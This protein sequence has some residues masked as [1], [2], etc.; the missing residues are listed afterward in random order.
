MEDN[1][2]KS[3]SNYVLKNKHQDVNNGY[4]LERDITTIGGVDQFAKGQIPIYKSSN[5]IITVNNEIAPKRDL[6]DDGFN[7]WTEEDLK[8]NTDVDEESDKIVVRQNFYK[9]KD[10]AYYG[11]CVELIRSSLNNI[12]INYPGSLVSSENNVYYTKNGELEILGKDGFNYLINNP[13]SINIHTEY[14]DEKKVENPIK[15][16]ANEGYKKYYKNITSYSISP[17]LCNN[18]NI[19][20]KKGEYIAEIDINGTKIRAYIGDEGRIYYLTNTKSNNVIAEPKIDVINEFFN[21]LD[22]FE[23]VLLNRNSTPKYTASFEVIDENDY[24]YDTEIRQFT[25]PMLD[26]YNLD[27]ITPAYDEYVNN[28]YYYA[29]FYDE[30]FCD[31]LYR[32][33]TH[34]SIKNFDWSY[35]RRYNNGDEKEY[36]IGGNKIKK[37]IRLFGREF[38][39]IKTYIDG[40]KNYN[41]IEYGETST[42]PEYFLNDS[43]INDG[44]DVVNI[45]PFSSSFTEIT[46]L[47]GIKPYS[48]DIVGKG[49]YRLCGEISPAN[50]DKIINIDDSII[51][52]N[53]IRNFSSE[54]EYSLKEINKH[55]MKILKLNSKSILSKKGTIEGIESL[56]SLFGLKSKRMNNENFD[57]EIKE[58]V[59]KTQKIEDKFDADK[60]IRPIDW[61]NS[62][63]TVVYNTDDFRNGNYIPY[64][65]LPIKGFLN[66]G[67]PID[68]LNNEELKDK[69]V[70]LYPYFSYDKIIDGHPYYQMD[71]GWNKKSHKFINNEESNGEIML[72]FDNNS[73]N[74]TYRSINTVETLNELVE[75]P[76]SNL[77]NNDVFFVEKVFNCALIDGIIYNIKTDETD[78]RYVNSFISNGLIKFGTRTFQDELTVSDANGNAFKYYL[79]D[80]PN[81]TE[82]KVYIKDDNTVIISGK[83]YSIGSFNVIDGD[84]ENKSNYFELN[85]IYSKNKI[86][87][88][89]WIRLTKDDVRLTE[90]K[91]IKDKFSGNNPHCGNLNYDGGYEYATYFSQLFKYPIENNLFNEECYNNFTDSFENIKTIGFKD[92]INDDCSL[93]LRN[94]EKILEI[95]ND[96]DDED[97]NTI[98]NVKNILISFNGNNPNEIKYYDYV[99]MNYLEQL[100]PST[101]ISKIDYSVNRDEC[102][103]KEEVIEYEIKGVE[104]EYIISSTGG[105]INLT[106]LLYKKTTKIFENCENE[107]NGS[108]I[109][110]N[111]EWTVVSDNDNIK[112]NG[113]E[114]TANINNTKN[115]IT[116]NITIS[117]KDLN[118][119]N[120]QIDPFTIKVVQPICEVTIDYTM[121]IDNSNIILEKCDIDVTNNIVVTGIKTQTIQNG[122]IV[123]DREVLTSDKYTIKYNPN[124]EKNETSDIKKYSFIITGKG[125]YKNCSVNGNITQKAGP[126]TISNNYDFSQAILIVNK[127]NNKI[128][129][130]IGEYEK[131]SIITSV[132]I[133]NVH[134]NVEG[135]TEIVKLSDIVRIKDGKTNYTITYNPYNNNQSTTDRI[136]NATV[137]MSNDYGNMTKSD[138]IINQ[139]GG[140]CTECTCEVTSIK[141]SNAKSNFRDILETEFNES[142]TNKT[143]YVELIDNNNKCKNCSGNISVF[144]GDTIFKNI[145]KTNGIT[146]LPISFKEIKNL[147]NPLT[148]LVKSDDNTEKYCSLIINRNCTPSEDYTHAKISFDAATPMAWDS[149]TT[150]ISN[151]KIIG[152]DGVSE[153][154]Q[155]ITEKEL[156]TSEYEV[157]YNPSGKN[158]SEKDR[159]VTITVKTIAKYGDRILENNKNIKQEHKPFSEYNDYTQAVL[160]F[161]HKEEIDWRKPSTQNYVTNV[162]LNNVIKHKID[163]SQEIINN[164]ALSKNEYTIL[165]SIDEENTKNFDEV[166]N[167]TVTVISDENHGK[168]SSNKEV[169]QTGTYYIEF[170]FSG[171]TP[172]NCCING[173]LKDSVSVNTSPA[174]VN[175]FKDFFYPIFIKDFEYMFAQESNNSG[176]VNN[177]TKVTNIPTCEVESVNRMF[178]NCRNLSEI[179]CLN[180]LNCNKIHDF[181]AMFEG[182][183]SIKYI[184][185]PSINT[186]NGVEFSYMFSNCSS[187]VELDVSHF[188]TSKASGWK[189][190]MRAMFQGCES[191]T[192]LNVS[193]FITSGV[194][195]MRFMF[196]GCKLL[197]ELDVTNFDTSKVK[198]MS[199]MFQNCET[200]TSLNVS[201]FNTTNVTDMSGMFKTC[202][203]IKDLSLNNFNTSKVV[204]MDSM[205][206]FSDKITELDLSNFNTNRLEITSF[207]FQQCSSLKTI[208][209]DG[210]NLDKVIWD[211][212]RPIKDGKE[213]M[214]KN[215]YSLRTIYLR[216]SNQSTIDKITS[217]VKIDLGYN[218]K[219]NIITI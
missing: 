54:K 105:T 133:D 28:L 183:K 21:K 80:L 168:I 117:A 37:L 41:N 69:D 11:S 164:M 95:K 201:N 108:Y 180:K 146:D 171:S 191:L 19:P 20:K 161:D 33:M 185:T 124:I 110:S 5:F 115:E 71:G 61:V 58:Y 76:I 118:N 81:G 189:G 27:F 208:I 175:V 101:I 193:N 86:G 188:D 138:I 56:L 166:N 214:F 10:F 94:D 74:E 64:Q 127:N 45:Y 145:R 70:T 205:F 126:C 165:Y 84:E 160:V 134:K 111:V 68:G 46:K 213:G 47:D 194:T 157:L 155:P 200:L 121:T 190:G 103:F 152:I 120:N 219:V 3:Y 6:I 29:K 75:L 24:G 218:N 119:P 106:P 187:L 150:T 73:Y 179:T 96:K 44:W 162:K 196:S 154:C 114:I 82:I 123:E 40:I 39:E 65:G 104:D 122:T 169:T 216:N 30:L 26:D 209:L 178:Y 163:G 87:D 42:M 2:I 15:Y 136:I 77:N 206:A 60:K 167:I 57:Y 62:T 125:K 173:N 55:F 203:N 22:T 8:N 211:P 217:Q 92:L 197:K 158:E 156:L 53:L 172:M 142:D 88:D 16:F 89:G 198:N 14:I 215:C 97:D 90:I 32:S 143:F 67:T 109:S 135:G 17:N 13:S 98:I 139:E 151:V 181:G 25:F 38:D 130:C 184:D 72:S 78:K 186:N 192:S 128:P 210:W 174:K 141:I 129:A 66:D 107:I 36:T 170:E 52:K 4:V 12:L 147:E 202:K 195:N 9:L 148:L 83:Y 49:Y 31:N 63:K 116:A 102:K 176:A 100:L 43:L 159:D 50:D 199:F 18:K 132:T 85:N 177:I 91:T 153:N 1:F 34:E 35:S 51:A 93:K 59:I 204:N 144:N 182:C 23:R 212:S 7:I 79:N 48:K 137:T 113:T 112:V 131:D 149:E 207:M 99:I 140:P